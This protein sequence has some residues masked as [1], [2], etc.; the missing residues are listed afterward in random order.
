MRLKSNLLA[1]PALAATVMSFTATDAK[2][3]KYTNIYPFVPYETSYINSEV[4]KLSEDSNFLKNFDKIHSMGLH[5]AKTKEKPWTSTFWPLNR[6][7][8][9][10]AY[11]DSIFYYNPFEVFSWETNRNKYRRRKENFHDKIK[12]LDS[13]ELAELAPSEK[14]DL[15]LGDDKFDLT[16][17]LWKYMQ[18]WGSMKEYGYLHSLDKVGGNTKAVQKMM[19]DNN[20]KNPDGTPYTK[21][22]ALEQAIEQRGGLAEH[23]AKKMVAAG[24]AGSVLDALP[25]ALQKAHSEKENFVI[26]R[27]NDFMATWEGICHGWST[28][29]GNMPRPRKAV[30]FRLKDG[31]DLKFYPEDIKGLVSLLWANS[32]IQDGKF[33]NDDGVNVGGGI[34]M[35]GMRCNDTDPAKDQWGRLYDHR[36]DFFSKKLEPRCVG[37]HPAIWH[38]G[39]VNVIGHQGRSFIVER[40]IEA[41]VDNHP[42]WKYDMDFFNPYTGSYSNNIGDV[43]VR[44]E[45]SKDQFSEFRNPE[46]K[47]IVGVKTAMTYLDWERPKRKN[48]DSEED[49]KEATKTM[50]YDLELDANGNIIGGQWRTKEVGKGSNHNQPDFFWVVTKDW[51]NYFGETTTIWKDGQQKQLPEWTDLSTTP[52]ADWKLAAEGAH[53]FVYQQTHDFGWSE[54]CEIKNEETGEV[55]KVACEYKI[56]KPQPLVNVVNKLLELSQ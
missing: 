7:L 50:L 4:E 43:K 16:N 30:S 22:E 47:F 53:S 17:R 56:N 15:L 37:V 20:W 40:K 36:P 44:Y 55:V 32:T 27:K 46:T 9:A 8:I 2:A 18:A 45:K 11:D 34:I 39:L 21:E 26:K 23:Y 52:P 25:Q 1:L 10:D 38:L 19:L 12:E 54:R 24:Q 3:E 13:D 42:M 31:R 49:D 14:Y 48:T 35:Q 28:A 6:G 33:L 29:A 51:R 41:A 5:K